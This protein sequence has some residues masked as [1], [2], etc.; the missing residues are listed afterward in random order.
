VA[1]VGLALVGIVVGLYL[2]MVLSA[3]VPLLLLV[4][5]P[6]WL[7][8]TILA[9]VRLVLAPVAA[10]VAPA[11]TSA[12]RTSWDL[13]RTRFWGLLGR[14]LLLAVI[15]FLFSILTSVVA[16]PFTAAVSGGSGAEVTPGADEVR[17]G[18]LMGNNPAVFS[19]GQLFSALGQGAATVL[20]SIG[21]ALIY[22][23]LQGPTAFVAA[24]DD[25]GV[26]GLSGPEAAGSGPSGH[27]V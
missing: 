22:R 23:R 13:T 1:L 24:E 19:I 15:S 2:V 4:T 5:L 14:L 7:V 8:G 16:A 6:L 11:G 3:A 17:L 9:T 27:G 18:D 12:L 20:W 10:A 26:P 25:G 21:L